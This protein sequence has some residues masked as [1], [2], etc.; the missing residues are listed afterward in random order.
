MLSADPSSGGI[1]AVLGRPGALLGGP[2]AIYAEGPVLKFQCVHFVP[3]ASRKVYTCHHS[4]FNLKEERT[5][6]HLH[7]VS[8]PSGMGA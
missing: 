5:G 3:L 6:L 7:F 1:G 2:G 4:G 8:S